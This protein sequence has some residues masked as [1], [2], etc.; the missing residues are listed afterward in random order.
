MEQRK[1]PD[2]GDLVRVAYE[3]DNGNEK[4]QDG[5]VD[6][7]EDDVSGGYTPDGENFYET[8]KVV[9]IDEDQANSHILVHLCEDGFSGV[10]RYSEFS[11]D[12]H[13][14]TDAEIEVL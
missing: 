4:T 14:G 6:D 11:G 3:D 2:E 10:M 8:E 9:W 1:L 13:L 7:V 5:R 12:F